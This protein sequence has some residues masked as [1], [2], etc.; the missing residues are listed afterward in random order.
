MRGG[1]QEQI[2]G[3]RQEQKRRR[4]FLKRALDSLSDPE[5]QIIVERHLRPEAT[6]LKD[7]GARFGLSGES[8]RKMELKALRAMRGMAA[9]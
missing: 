2:L 9:A 1:D 7:L 6:P 4:E 8:I 3:D 5:R